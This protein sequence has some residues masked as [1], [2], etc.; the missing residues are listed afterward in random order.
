MIIITIM[1]FTKIL[2]QNNFLSYCSSFPSQFS[3]QHVRGYQDS[4]KNYKELDIKAYL[5]IDVYTTVT[6]TVSI[7]VNMHIISLHFALYIGDKYDHYR[8]NHS[9]R[10][11]SYSHEAQ[12]FLQNKYK[13]SSS[14]FHSINQN[15]YF[16]SL[17]SIPDFLKRLTLRF[18]HHRISAEKYSS[19]LLSLLL[20]VIF[21]LLLP[22]P[23]RS[24]P[25]LLAN[26]NPRSQLIT[27]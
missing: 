26:R 14:A 1:D 7:P 12:S 2:K 19:K 11:A 8:P 17:R 27:N 20:I 3:I 9:I 18:I 25:H 10:V 23:P 22:L 16:S 21:R 4:N 6:E 13:W 15:I 5:N 24:L